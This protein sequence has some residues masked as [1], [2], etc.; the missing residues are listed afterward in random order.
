M[1][2]RFLRLWMLVFLGLM[3]F[4]VYFTWKYILLLIL[5]TLVILLPALMR[6]QKFFEKFP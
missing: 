2:R 4:V 3:I 5:I 6:I 1:D